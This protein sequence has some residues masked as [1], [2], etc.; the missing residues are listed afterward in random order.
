M[1]IVRCWK[2][3]RSGLLCECEVATARHSSEEPQ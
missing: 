3:G 1:T 2:C